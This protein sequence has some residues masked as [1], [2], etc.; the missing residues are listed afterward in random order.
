MQTRGILFGS[1][2]NALR[3]NFKCTNL[4][5]FKN[6]FSTDNSKIEIYDD[7]NVN[8]K[9]LD[10]RGKSEIF[11]DNFIS[12]VGNDLAGVRMS[13]CW[14]KIREISPVVTC[15]T[16]A[17][18]TQRI[19]DFLLSAGALSLAT[20]DS[21]DLL[22]YINKSAAIYYNASMNT[23][24]NVL[25]EAL[26]SY[27]NADPPLKQQFLVLDTTNFGIDEYRNNQIKSIIE[28]CRPDVIKCNAYE[29]IC[30]AEDR[31]LIR[32][33]LINPT[34][35]DIISACKVVAHRYEAVVQFTG[36]VDIVASSCGKQIAKVPFDTKQA[37]KFAGS[38]S[39]VAGLCAAALAA[40]DGDNFLAACTS[41]MAYKSCARDALRESKG[42][43]SVVVSILDKI[44]RLSLSPDNLIS[45]KIEIFHDS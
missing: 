40:A 42:P 5:H 20:Q 35:D 44:F 41:L 27:R 25:L 23:L 18:N 29:I 32:G 28:N 34:V 12:N 31:T 37:N 26:S 21:K 14:R 16:D 10:D 43:G 7:N 3:F 11:L 15:I 2:S 22:Q 6:R 8:V 33:E 4:N 30:L 24:Q 38:G 36:V 13:S 39:C 9:R 19:I 45:E 17:S 1:L